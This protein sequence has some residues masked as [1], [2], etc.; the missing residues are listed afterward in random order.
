MGIV[1]A[2]DVSS[3]QGSDIRHLLDQFQPQLVIVKVYLPQELGSTGAWDYT[4]PQAEQALNAG[5]SVGGYFWCYADLDPRQSVRD[6]NAVAMLAGIQFSADSPLWLDI[7]TYTD[8]SIPDL[9]WIAEAEAEAAVLGI[10][11]GIYTSRE[12]WR[13]C[14]GDGDNPAFSHLPLWAAQY[15]P[16]T[17]S[18]DD[19]APFGGWPT[20]LGRQ[21]TSD[22]IDQNVF[23]EVDGL[24]DEQKAA[25]REIAA[26]GLDKALRIGGYGAEL[27]N[28]QHPNYA[29]ALTST[30]LELRDLMMRL[31]SLAD[32]T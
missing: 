12:M 7:E 10:P 22:P 3:H 23:R 27:A 14:T 11:V 4:I 2:I 16:P 25:I 5:C 1:T 20:C 15:A 17:P 9:N 26:D 19:Y 30:D 18:L 13:R 24:T 32:E 28:L 8:G 29:E 6:A 31:N 21:W